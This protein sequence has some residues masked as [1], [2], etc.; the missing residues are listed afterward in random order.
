MTLFLNYVEIGLKGPP[1]SKL[2]E[3]NVC[4]CVCVSKDTRKG[5]VF[6]CMYSFS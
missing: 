6:V 2:E 3:E 1:T 5:S 4:V